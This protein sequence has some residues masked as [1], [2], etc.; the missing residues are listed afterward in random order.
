MLTKEFGLTVKEVSKGF[1]VVSHSDGW[2]LLKIGIEC[3]ALLEIAVFIGLLLFYPAFTWRRKSL[4]LVLG[5]TGTYIVNLFRLMLIVAI[6]TF[7]GRGAIFPA[8]AIFGRGFFFILIVIIY[9]FIITK[10]TLNL[11]NKEV[12]ARL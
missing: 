10:P 9:W 2:S 7:W 1:V 8:H 11:L 5:V 3:S 4:Y 6:I 12:K